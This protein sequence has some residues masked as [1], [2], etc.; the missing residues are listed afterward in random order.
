MS[1]MNI[2]LATLSLAFIFS[3][4]F[5]D[6]AQA[7]MDAYMYGEFWRDHLL[8]VAR[9]LLLSSCCWPYKLLGTGIPVIHVYAGICKRR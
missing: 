7:W 2:A 5:D 6:A 3:I 1:S 9:Y 4:L 8:R